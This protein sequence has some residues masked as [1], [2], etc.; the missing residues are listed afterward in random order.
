MPS[1][2][3]ERHD[4]YLAN[5]RRTG[6]RKIIGIGRVTSARRRDGHTF[7][8]ELS[9]GEAWVGDQRI[10]T[11]FI[12]DITQRQQAEAQLKDLQAELAHFGRVSEMATLASSLAH[13]LNEPLTAVTSYCQSIRHL[14]RA[15]ADPSTR[16]LI[17][18]AADEAANEALRAGEIVRHLRDFF[19]RGDTE[20][21]VEVLPR[22]ITEANA[23]ALVGSRELGIEVQVALDPEAELVLADRVQIQQVLINLIRN[24]MDAM[25]DAEERLLTITTA[26]GPGNLVTIAVQDTGSGISDAIASQLFQPFVTSKPTGM[27]IGL[28]I[29]RT[30]IEAHG[31]RS[32]SRAPRKVGLFLD[33]LYRAWGRPMNDQAKLVHLV[34]D[35]PSVRRS[36]AFMLKTF[37]HLVEAYEFGDDLLRAAS[38]MRTGCILLDIRMPGLDG[39]ETQEE[40]RKRGVALPIIIMTGHGDVS[41]AVS[42]MKAGAIDFIEKPVDSDVLMSALAVAFGRLSNKA[43]TGERK[44]DAEVR[45]RSLT[46]RENDVLKGLAQGLPNKTI[47]YDLGISP[48]TVE[49]HRGNLMTKLGVRSLSEALRIAFAAE[50]EG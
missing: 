24:A 32:G 23:L 43:A 5:Y 16:E 3:R 8:I 19:A 18:E 20:R 6:E 15:E 9:I 45:L 14:A 49:I 48:R 40:L 35:D 44:R 29:C 27:G 1:P 12:H 26:E 10:F 37:G 2:D 11:G 33:S 13:E 50:G 38:H 42:A 47:A 39:L 34:D 4:G 30:I 22:L 28:S 17:A 25:V 21:Q 46:P 7:P 36:V 41:L 31:G